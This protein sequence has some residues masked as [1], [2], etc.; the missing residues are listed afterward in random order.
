M[1]VETIT[2]KNEDSPI[3]KVYNELKTEY[4]G[5]ERIFIEDGVI[6]VYS[7][8]ETLWKIFEEKIENYKSIEFDAGIE[9]SHFIKVT[10]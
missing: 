2:L 5:I 4:T 3:N 9:E 7:N 8:D 1:K 6:I 10:P